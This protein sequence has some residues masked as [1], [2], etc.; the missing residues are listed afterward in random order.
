MVG[1]IACTV[2]YSIMFQTGSL[3]TDWSQIMACKVFR[4]KS[5]VNFNHEKTLKEVYSNKS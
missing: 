1:A 5:L 2:N 4:L 3:K